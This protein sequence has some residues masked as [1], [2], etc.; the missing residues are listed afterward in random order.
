MGYRSG[1]LVSAVAMALVAAA[2]AQGANYPSGGSDFAVDVQGWTGSDTS[3]TG[4]TGSLCST[5]TPYETAA[6]N[7]PGSISVRM[8]TTVNAGG[9]FVGGHLDL[10][11]VHR[12]R[13]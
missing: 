1:M 6:G 10:A 12:A 2:P 11:R 5:S 8:S 4:G 13:R 9:T 3:C 7:P